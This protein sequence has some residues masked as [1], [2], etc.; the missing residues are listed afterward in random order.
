MSDATAG[1]AAVGGGLEPTHPTVGRRGL[2]SGLRS[3]ELWQR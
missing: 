2:H 3:W 1:E